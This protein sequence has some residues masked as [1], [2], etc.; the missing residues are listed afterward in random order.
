MRLISEK[1]QANKIIRKINVKNLL[2]KDDDRR[3]E[4]FSLMIPGRERQFFK[5]IQQ[6][7]GQKND[8]PNEI[9]VGDKKFKGD[10]VLSI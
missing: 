5:T 4:L 9:N 8:F 6:W 1:K 2:E 7:R 3:A 10:E